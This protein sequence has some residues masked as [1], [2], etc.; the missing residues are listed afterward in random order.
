MAPEVLERCYGPEADIW[1]VGVVVFLMLAGRLPFDGAT[2]RQIIKA[3]LD[4]DP[5]FQ[6]PAWNGISAS[7]KDCVARMLVKDPKQRASVQQLLAHPWLAGRMRSSC[8]SNAGDTAACGAEGSCNACGVSSSHAHQTADC[9]C[10][11]GRGSARHLQRIDSSASSS[12]SRVCGVSWA[13]PCATELDSSCASPRQRRDSSPTPRK[14][15][16]S[17]LKHVRSRADLQ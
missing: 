5:D 7:A 13:A 16:L 15:V 4:S 17:P 8:C 10:G 6:H 14:P 2:D 3:V 9:L 1:S 11:A 12:S